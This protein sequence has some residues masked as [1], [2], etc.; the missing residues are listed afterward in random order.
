MIIILAVTIILLVNFDQCY[1]NNIDSIS[2]HSG[3]IVN[4]NNSD[5]NDDGSS[6]N[7]ILKRT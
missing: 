6:S 7:V 1:N 5:D 3:N 2:S 4:N